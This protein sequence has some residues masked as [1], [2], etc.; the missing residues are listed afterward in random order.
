MMSSATKLKL[1]IVAVAVVLLLLGGLFWYFRVHTKTPEYALHAI[2]DALDRNDEAL[3]LRHVRL[4]AV[5]DAG[6]DDF[7]RGTMD[8]EF[9]HSREASAA[10]E[11]FSKMLK[12]AFINMLKDAVHTRLTTGEWP[13]ADAI[14]EGTDTE[15][16]LSRIGVRDLTFR[17]I[18]R[19]TRDEEAQTAEADIVAHQG[20]ADADF[21]FKILLAPSEEGDWQVVSIQN[22]H[23]Y[24]VLLEQARRL[25]VEAYLEETDAIIARHDQTSGAAQLRLYSVLGAGA[26][27]SQATRD[28]ARQIME[29]DILVDWQERKDELAAVSV[30]RSMQSLHQLRLKICDLHIAYAQ[31]YASWMTDKNAAT[32]RSAESSLRQAEVLEA[33][34]SFLV[35]RAK[36]SF[37]DKVE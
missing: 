35:Q 26:L 24:A 9:G 8:A 12:P 13:S 37:G 22:L 17:E 21:T 7:M 14:E 2:E 10:L 15:S 16:I 3:F 11:D 29:Q 20:E 19:L 4:D 23:E 28:M 18:A 33:E 1:S 34:A 32:I 30:P 25:R 6:Y 5:L 31:G 36:R 27:G